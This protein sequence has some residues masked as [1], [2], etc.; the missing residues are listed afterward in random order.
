[1]E[2][3]NNNPLKQYFRRPA[4]YIKLP[5]EGK[6][7]A[8]G[9]VTIPENGEI[10]VFPMTAIDEITAKTPDALFNG[11]A[12][13]ELMK[14]CIPDI[15][16]PWLINSTDLDSILIAIKAASGGSELEIESQCPSCSE[17]AKYGINL[18]SILTNMKAVDYSQT[19]KIN[20]LEVKF[21]PLI[22]KE[23]NQASIG[24]FEVQRIFIEMENTEDE[25]KKAELSQKALK[26]VTELTMEILAKTIEFI[27]TPTAKV[28]E[29]K[30]ILDFLQNCDKKIYIAIRD[31]NAELKTSA[32]LQPLDV[33]CIH[34][35]H[36][37]KQ[38]F[39]LNPS[40]FF[41]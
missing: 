29:R 10:P 41:V 25:Q 6:D 22:Y 24:Q 30:F 18:V 7:Y 5:S 19:L 27:Q 1:M 8:P 20:D 31:F 17:A 11:T 36:I 3:T 14:S 16:D 35:S 33:K 4:L 39:T 12:V 40:D 21:K 38:P 23:M 28:V 32:E 13:T 9:V 15:K 2:L 26:S 37:Y 34:C